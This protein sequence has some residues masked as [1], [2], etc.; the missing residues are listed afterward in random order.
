MGTTGVV[1]DSTADFTGNAVAK[2]GISI[3][4][5]VVNW[6]GQSYKDK[7]DLS[8]EDFYARLGASKTS[9]TTGAPSMGS[10]E[11]AFR[12]QL[13]KHESV[14]CICLASGLSATYDVASRAAENVDTQRIKVIDSRTLTVGLGWIAEAAAE[15]GARGVPLAEI[16]SQVESMADR[17]RILVTMNSLEY[18]R[19]GGRIGRAQAFAGTLLNVKPI[20]S[21]QDG[22]VH[23]VERVRTL[24]GALRRIVELAGNFG[25]VERLAVMEGDGNESAAELTS[26]IAAKFPGRP[27]GQGQIGSVLGTHGGPG[28]AGVVA[29][30]RG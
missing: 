22:A 14:V 3:V 7:V 17:I 9:P 4:P 28:V 26:M 30:L 21:I 10:F 1:T 20:L 19:R 5:L 11:A 29:L 18:L 12:E 8:T 6:D 13:E 16:V 25:P 23:P 2:Y 24:S 27:D 15:Q